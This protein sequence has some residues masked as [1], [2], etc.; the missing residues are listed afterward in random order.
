MPA[1]LSEERLLAVYLVLLGVG[2]VAALGLALLGDPGEPLPLAPLSQAVLVACLT[3]FGGAGVLALRLFG[4]SV[5]LSLVAALLFAGLSAALFALLAAA[6]SRAA[7]R[8]K[9]FADLV[10]ALARVVTPI[11]PGRP[12]LIATNGARPALTLPATSRDDR[13]LPTGATVVVTALRGTAAEVVPL[14]GDD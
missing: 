10:G 9:A 6:A 7:E 13:P 3:C 8:R 12:G 2:V 11:E 5:G 4:F 14:P 1:W